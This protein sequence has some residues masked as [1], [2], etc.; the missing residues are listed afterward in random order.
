MRKS[1][2][3][4]RRFPS[5]GYRGRRTCQSRSAWSP[6]RLQLRLTPSTLTS[7][8]P[9]SQAA[10]RGRDVYPRSCPH[11]KRSAAFRFSRATGECDCMAEDAHVPCR[12][13]CTTHGSGALPT[14]G[15]EPSCLF[16]LGRAWRARTRL[17]ASPAPGT[18]RARTIART[19]PLG[20]QLLEVRCDRLRCLFV[21]DG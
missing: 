3:S 11:W 4:P 1:P 16:C 5:S 20:E 18:H 7:S 21:T 8:Q 10:A 12:Y 19:L 2:P 14:R 13:W 17:S 6:R 9:A 15:R